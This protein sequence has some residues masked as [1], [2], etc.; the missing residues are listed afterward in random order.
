[1]YMC[2]CPTLLITSGMLWHDMNSNMID[3]KINSFCM[4]AIV[5]INGGCGFVIE[6]QLKLITVTNLIRLT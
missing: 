4:A 3:L 2:V 5:S 6:A 1:M